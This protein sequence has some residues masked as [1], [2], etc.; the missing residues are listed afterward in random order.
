MKPNNSGVLHRFAVWIP[1]KAAEYAR[2]PHAS[3]DLN[4]LAHCAKRLECARIPPL[5]IIRSLA[6]FDHQIRN[7]NSRKQC[8]VVKE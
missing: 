6:G 4:A 5:L 3:R 8:I 7:P 1:T 2:T